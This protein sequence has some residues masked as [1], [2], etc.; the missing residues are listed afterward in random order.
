MRGEDVRVAFPKV[1]CGDV[2]PDFQRMELP[3][4]SCQSSPFG[5]TRAGSYPPDSIGELAGWRIALGDCRMPG[6][7]R[8][9]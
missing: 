8:R 2:F 5:V 1:G 6:F 4:L 3:K 9:A 7:D